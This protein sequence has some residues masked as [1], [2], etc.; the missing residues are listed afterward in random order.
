MPE[1]GFHRVEQ[2]MGTAI[3]VDVRDAD[4]RPG[5]LDDVFAW[6]HRVDETFSTYKDQSQISRLGRGEIKVADCD[7]DVEWVLDRCEEI[8]GITGGYFDAWAGGMLDPS[9]LVKGWSV[10]VASSMLVDRGS[11][12]HCINAGGDI[13]LRGEPE[14]GRPWHVGISHPLEGDVLTVVV[15]GHELAVATSGKAERGW[16][17]IDPLAGRPAAALASVT[18]VGTELALTDAYATAAVAMGLDAP[19]WLESLPDHDAYVI[20]ARGHVWWTAGFIRHAPALP[21]AQRPRLAHRA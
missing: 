17:V 20:D 16:H 21:T 14:P 1:A 13:R 18:L 9:G 5:A 15:I 11:T 7:P 10:E 3:S 8:R 4:V 12:N 2:V 19:L 6:F